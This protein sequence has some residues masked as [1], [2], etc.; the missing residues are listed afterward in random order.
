MCKG[1]HLVHFPASQRPPP[2]V[3]KTNLL[4]DWKELIR[5]T[6]EIFTNE[7]LSMKKRRKQMKRMFDPHKSLVVTVSS[8]SLAL[9]FQDLACKNELSNNLVKKELLFFKK[10]LFC[11]L[12]H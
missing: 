8:K 7:E 3:T 9:L 10:E 2:C 12:L 11:H 4:F 5:T 1:L 6:N